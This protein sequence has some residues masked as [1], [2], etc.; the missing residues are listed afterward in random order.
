[1]TQ[2]SGGCTIGGVDQEGE[3]NSS[4]SPEV[5][6]APLSRMNQAS[7]QGFKTRGEHDYHLHAMYPEIAITQD[8]GT[9]NCCCFL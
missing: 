1:M 3:A 6:L 7:A 4:S 2:S 8:P 5:H 9:P